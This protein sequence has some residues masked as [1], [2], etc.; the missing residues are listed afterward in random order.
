MT[1]LISNDPGNVWCPYYHVQAGSKVYY[2]YERHVSAG[3]TP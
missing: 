1:D 3:T 2:V